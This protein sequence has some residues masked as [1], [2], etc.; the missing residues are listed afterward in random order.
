MAFLLRRPFIF[1]T[2]GIIAIV[3]VAILY[4][5]VLTP[6]P[7]LPEFSSTT[8]ERSSITMGLNT[9]L[10]ITIENKAP[11]PKSVEFR[12]VYGSPQLLFYDKINGTLL[13][14]SPILVYNGM[15]YTIT[16]P[17]IRVMNAGEQWSLPIWIKGL[18]PGGSS[19]TYTIYLEIYSDNKLSQRTSIQLTVN[20]P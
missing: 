5:G 14:V 2:I 16:Y 12:I 20:R 3:V 13:S 15:N 18:D 4:T 11:N 17:K 8:L 10:T 7:S 19:Y 9:T 1:F 6:K